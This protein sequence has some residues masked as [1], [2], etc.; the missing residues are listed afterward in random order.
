MAQAR[1]EIPLLRKNRPKRF[2]KRSVALQKQSESAL[3]YKCNRRLP[4][5]LQEP[6]ILTNF[7][8]DPRFHVDVKYLPQIG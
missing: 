8:D 5:V 1:S 2:P 4:D 6:Q 7:A 3:S